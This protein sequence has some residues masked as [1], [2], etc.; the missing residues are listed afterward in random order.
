MKK[1]LFLSILAFFAL[2]SANVFGQN[3]GTSAIYPSVGDINNYSVH[4][5]SGSTYAWS[6]QATANGGGAELFGDTSSTTA[7]ATATTASTTSN[8]VT[9]TWVNPTVGKIYYLHLTESNTGGCTNRKVLAIQPANNFR[10]D[11][12]N[13]DLNGDLLNGGTNSVTYSICA[14]EINT[15]AWTGT[16]PVTDATARSFT[17]DYGSRTFYYKITAKGINFSNTTWT[18]N[19]TISQTNGQYATVTIDTKVGTAAWVAPSTILTS[20]N[21]T[22]SPTIPVGAGNDVILV[23]VTVTNNVGN[24]SNANENLS[25]NKYTITLNSGKDQNLNPAKSL[26]NTSTTQTQLARP[27]SGEIQY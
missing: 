27:D 13:V 4:L 22:F 23:K 12:A 6:L 19:I 25:D 14:P 16:D 9:V 1:L 3:T 8:T 10:L 7:V 24:F 17:Y 20:T 5:N 21:N 11:I 15:I 26:G 18:P 2:V